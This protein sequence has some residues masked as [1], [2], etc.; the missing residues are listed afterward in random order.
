MG[1]R[2]LR[3]SLISLLVLL[4]LAGTALAADHVVIVTDNPGELFDPRLL[5]IQVGDTVTWKNVAGTHNVVADDL[6]FTSG[7]PTAAPWTFTHTF[8]AEGSF[9]YSCTLH[10]GQT[11]T[12]VVRPARAANEIAYTVNAWDMTRV[13][14]D[15][16]SDDSTEF[17]RTMGTFVCGVRLPS[18]AKLTGIELSACHETTDTG[19]VQ[20]GLSICPEP[21]QD[22]TMILSVVSEKTGVSRPCRVFTTD[23]ADGPIIDNLNN[24]YGLQVFVVDQTFRSVKLYYKRGLSPA[25]ATATFAD[26][27]TNN[28]F[29]RVI[30]ALAAS[31]ITQG[32]GNG[33]FCPNDPVTRGSMASFLARALGLFW[34]N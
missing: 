11:G 7:D 3:P 23:L 9:D 28:Q 12:I 18:G 4:S 1:R 30:E 2:R 15:N 29:F 34:A 33:N 16:S 25:P 20:A 26:V 14:G 21:M 19:S 8:P 27:P 24:T 5:T 32:C 22:C 31:G 13:V 10:A 6:S 17:R